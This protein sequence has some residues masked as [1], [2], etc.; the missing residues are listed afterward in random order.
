MDTEDKGYPA[1]P[2]EGEWNKWKRK[3]IQSRI[4]GNFV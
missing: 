3:N 1:C 2:P 4:Q